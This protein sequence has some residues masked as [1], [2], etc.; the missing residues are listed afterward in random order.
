MIEIPDFATKISSIVASNGVSFIEATIEL[1][2]NE[3][4]EIEFLAEVIRNNPLLF[5]TIE[6]EAQSLHC[7]KKEFFHE[8]LP[9]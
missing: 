6:K 2:N 3:N 8:R 9:L 4:Y 7:I 1:C 5:N